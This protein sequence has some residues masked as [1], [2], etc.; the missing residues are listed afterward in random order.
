VPFNSG[1]LSLC[2]R[3]VFQRDLSRIEKYAGK[4]PMRFR[5]NKWKFLHLTWSNLMHQSRPVAPWL[6]SSTA[7][8]DLAS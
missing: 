1:K 4:N 7:E 2:S 3:V 8:K 6:S 5:D